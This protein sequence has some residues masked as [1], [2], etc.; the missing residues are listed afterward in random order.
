MTP[1]RHRLAFLLPVLLAACSSALEPTAC[2]SDEA[3]PAGSRCRGDVCV[4]DSPPVASI[5][6]PGTLEAFALVE[7]DGSPTRDP[8]GPDDVAEH[9]WSV[10]AVTAPCAAPSVAGRTPVARVRFGCSGRYEVSLTA[11][12]RAGVESEPETLEVDVQP[13]SRPPTVLAGADLASEHLCEG[14]P[15]ACRAIAPLALSSTGPAGA[16][17]RWT[18]EPPLDRPLD[19]TRRVTFDPAPD[20]PAPAVSIETDGTAISGD[21]IFRV[22]ARDEYGPVGAAYTRVSVTNRAP[23]VVAAAP[24][25]VPHAF[26]A[27]RSRFVASG[28]VALAAVDPDGDSLEVA[29][30]LRH[31]GD[32]ASSFAGELLEDRVIFSIEVP[33]Q[34]PEDALHLIGGPELARTVEIVAVD[35]N[36]VAA[37]AAVPIVVA[38]R[39]PAPV[40]APAP[41]RAP[42]RF[43]AGAARY[44]A[45]AE[46]GSWT[47][48]DGDPLWA[49]PAAAPCADVSVVD[50]IARV[51]CSV[52]YE[53]V[54]AVDRIAGSH[55]VALRVRDPWVEGPAFV[56]TVE[57]LNTPPRL[58]VAVDPPT[59]TAYRYA[60][61]GIGNVEICD[62]GRVSARV[63]DPSFTATPS[64]LDPDGDPV[65]LAPSTS[66]LAWTSSAS[67]A[68]AL[69]AGPSCVSFAF[70]LGMIRRLCPDDGPLATLLASDGAASVEAAASPAVVFRR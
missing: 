58:A 36:R 52:A 27:G 64:V 29:G 56:Q 12:D 46:L 37:R 3:C 41:V 51:E 57:V 7:L 20:H 11:V 32:G 24:E 31:V 65:L 30:V 42:H 6:R 5:R 13:S 21:W 40:G 62:D 48:A 9:R 8:D 28:E 14:E 19:G 34:A 15:L 38:N 66:P 50:G 10:R 45:A 2:H 26:D 17:L 47:D 23:I 4:A 25:S 54:P 44:V 59:V 69:C 16:A 49:A 18:V 22:E 60:T 1:P 61:A 53:G 39:P 68:S 67:P 63:Y 35:V 55:L 43:D 33:Y 70:S